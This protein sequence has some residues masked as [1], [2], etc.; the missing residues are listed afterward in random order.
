[1]WP[2][3]QLSLIVFYY[4]YYL[5]CEAIGTA[6]TPGLLCQPRVIVKTIVEK[7][8]E[9]RLAGETEVLGGNLPHH[10]CPSQNPTWPDPCLNPGR[11]GGKPA[12]NRLIYGAALPHSKSRIF[13]PH[14]SALLTNSTN[15]HSIF[16]VRDSIVKLAI[17]KFMNLPTGCYR[18]RKH[19]SR[20]DVFHAQERPVA[21][22]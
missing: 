12:T 8:M 4:Y 2:I 7:Q 16:W 18:G 5:V 17:N 20:W 19:L 14:F 1:V 21:E 3:Y 9:C 11:R 6:S 15:C 22:Q 10:F 13:L